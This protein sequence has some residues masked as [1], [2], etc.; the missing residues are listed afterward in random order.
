M[1]KAINRK[2]FYD[3]KDE[4]PDYKP[5]YEYIQRRITSAV[6]RFDLSTGRKPV[7]KRPL[8]ANEDVYDYDY[9]TKQNVSHV[10]KKY[11]SSN[12]EHSTLTRMPCW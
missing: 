5:N 1:K 8:T 3:A 7:A 4:L 9:Y 12:S 11:L 10:Y 6:P 2:G